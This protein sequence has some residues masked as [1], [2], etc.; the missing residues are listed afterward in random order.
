[1][2]HHYTLLGFSFSSYHMLRCRRDTNLLENTNVQKSKQ[3]HIC[4]FSKI[5]LLVIFVSMSVHICSHIFAMKLFIDIIQCQLYHFWHFQTA[6]FEELAKY[7]SMSKY[8]SSYK[9]LLNGFFKKKLNSWFSPKNIDWFS[10]KYIN[11]L[12]AIIHSLHHTK[13]FWWQLF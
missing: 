4:A 10:Y 13:C 8:C 5:I 9:I 2:H 6:L 12:T 3:F 1:M 7:K 11:S